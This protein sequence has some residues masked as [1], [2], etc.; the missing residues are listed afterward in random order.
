M[1]VVSAWMAGDLRR[2]FE[3]SHQRVGGDQ[4]QLATDG[5][6]RNRV[7]VEIEAN[8][9]G[10]RRPHRQNEIGLERMS[11]LRQQARLFFGED[12]GNGAAVVS[13][14]ASPVRHLIAPEQCLPIAFGERG[15][16]TARPEGFA[17][18]AN[19]SL[20]AAFLIAGA[21]LTGAC[22]E[23]IMSAQLHQSRVE[24]DLVAPAFEHRAAKV[25]VENHARLAGPVLEGMNMSAQKVLHRLVEEELQIQRP[26]PRQRGH[27]AGQRASRAAH[28]DLAEVSPVH[29][30]L[31]GGECL[32]VQERLRA[33]A[34]AAGP[35]RGAAG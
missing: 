11:G 29:L 7:I 30:G 28:G 13:G 10:L 35:R 6:G 3:D 33:P 22:D 1:A 19:G 26:R 4:R 25:V 32:Q 17:H 27:E 24:V 18:I 5:F 16:G 8:I 23:V 9:D 21:D 20:H 2:A 34:G 14:P 12:L 31:F 15:E